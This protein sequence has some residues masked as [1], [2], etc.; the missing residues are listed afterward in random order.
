MLL[1][2]KTSKLNFDLEIKTKLHEKMK[3]DERHKLYIIQTSLERSSS[4]NNPIVIFRVF[5]FLKKCGQKK[6]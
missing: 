5:T 2:K 6:N 4:Y 1:E 3:V